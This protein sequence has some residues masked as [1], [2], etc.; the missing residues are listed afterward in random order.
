[1]SILRWSLLSAAVLVLCSLIPYSLEPAE[2]FSGYAL[3]PGFI[4]G[5]YASAMFSGYPHGVEIVP[6]LVISSVVNFFFWTAVSYGA[7]SALRRFLK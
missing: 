2:P 1:M 4:L 7:L 3:S 6:M 5:M